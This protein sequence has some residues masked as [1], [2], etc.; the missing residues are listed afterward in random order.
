MCKTRLN[1]KRIS[2]GILL[3]LQIC[4]IS[5]FF[6]MQPSYKQS[7]RSSVSFLVATPNN[8]TD[9][10]PTTYH[11]SHSKILLKSI[12]TRKL[13]EDFNSSLCYKKGTDIKLMKRSHNTWKCECLP[14]YHGID[15]GQAEVIWRTLLTLRKPIQLKGRSFER[16]IIYI[17]EISEI[18]RTISD[19]R[20]NELNQ[21]VDLFVLYE[22][23][24]DFMGNQMTYN[25]LKEF[26]DKILYLR[27]TKVDKLWFQVN[28]V[29]GN[30]KQDDL[31]LVSGFNEIPNVAAL[32]FFKLYDNWPEPISFRL[33]WSVF[34]FFWIHPN[35][36]FL[37][38]QA[39]TKKYLYEGLNNRLSSII[40]NNKTTSNFNIGDLNHYGGWY[41]EFC[42]DPI[43]IIDELN[44]L[45]KQI[46]DDGNAKTIDANYVEEL[47]ENGIYIDGKTELLRAHRFRESYFA[48][49]FL[50][51]NTWKYDYLMLN[52]YSKMDYY[53]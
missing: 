16:R 51:E 4:V 46:F 10:K 31:I 14:G 15:C 38:V 42:N 44:R 19:I 21:T 13:Y 9:S 48:P 8:K 26:H 5:L 40:S 1:L 11:T 23:N 18:T 27:V 28:R 17:F 25:F 3:I 34:G 33:R 2:V 45:P 39:F 6:N 20:L 49:T 22:L 35:K 36:T 24:S 43:K 41:C 47:I 30:L 29:I 12:N 32:Q 37:K 52:I 7:S 50:T 53:E